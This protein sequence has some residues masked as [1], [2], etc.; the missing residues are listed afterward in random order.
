MERTSEETRTI[1]VA[2]S[3]TAEPLAEPLRFW[4]GE[5]GLPGAVAFAPHGQIFQALL[6]PTSACRTN[7]HGLNVVLV[8]ADDLCA[9]IP[10]DPARCG[11]AC[12]ALARSAED[13]AAAVAEAAARSAAPLLLCWCP[14]SPRLLRHPALAAAVEQ[15]AARL[16]AATGDLGSVR[17]LAAAEISGPFPDLSY[18]DPHRDRLARVPYTP[19]F[20]AAVAGAIARRWRALATGP[21]KVIA[22][23]CDDT[24]WKGIVGEDGADGIVVDAGRRALQAF[25]VDEQARGT[26]VCLCSKNEPRDVLEVLATHPEMTLREHHLAAWRIDWNAKS[27]GLRSL[28]AELGVGLDSFAFIDDSALEC[29]EVRARCPEVLAL[30]LPADTDRIPQWL[31]GLWAFDRWSTTDEDRER[32]TMVRQSRERE[33]VRRASASLA[34]FMR[35]LD[36]EL[37]VSPLEPEEAA[38]AAQ[39]TQRTNQFHATTVRRTESEVRALAER[40]DTDVLTVRVRDRF[41][42]YGL[43]GVLVCRAEGAALRVESFL[44]SCRV[45]G[46]GVEHRLLAE[47]ARIAE[48]RGLTRIEIPFLPSAKNRPAADFLDRFGACDDSRS[49]DG[50]RTYAISLEAAR[51]APAAAVRAP[52]GEASAVVPAVTPA[53]GPSGDGEL[54]RRIADELADPHRVA[55]RVAGARRARPGGAPAPVPPRTPLE[56]LLAAKASDC[57][58]I[59]AVGVDDDFFE[60]GGDSLIG[61]LLLSRIHEATGVALEL[62]ALFEGPTIRMLAEAVERAQLATVGEADLGEAIAALAHLS[63]DE[64]RALL[65]EERGSADG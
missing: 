35:S 6:D 23:D 40:D 45:L 50:G 21:R 24:L 44:L 33:Q 34:D 8:R 52:A 63:D 59:A 13:L 3:F 43:T 58:G 9:A 17:M 51:E 47:L 31:S 32:T 26:L 18:H 46:R 29:A 30:Q 38:R 12:A 20:Y 64:V 57:L 14:A 54:L 11:D 65:E 55:A 19:A 7:A 1:V 49:A 60:L 4:L 41:G 36:L 53:S 5:L 61:T 15:A 42:D 2:A 37:R 22:V 48:C 16:A 10:D 56:S 28:A 62:R 27:E 39:L 25:L